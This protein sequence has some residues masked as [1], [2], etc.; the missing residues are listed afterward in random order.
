[1]ALSVHPYLMFQGDAQ[2]A[3]DLYQA[4]FP[5]AVLDV[6]DRHGEGEGP[7]EGAFKRG[8][9][10]IAGQTV[11]IFDSP[12]VHG[13][14]FTPS[15]SLFVTCGSEQELRHLADRL[16]EGGSIMMPAGDYGFS[17]LFAWVSDRFGVSWQLNLA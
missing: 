13:F 8:A 7:H 16:G 4:A 2:A 3:I 15:F 6:I 11:M 12:P 14:T 9:L 17:A 1:M 10:T 5:D